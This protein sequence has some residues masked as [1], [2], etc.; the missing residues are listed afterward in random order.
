MPIPVSETSNATTEAAPL[1]NR[2]IFAPAASRH[3]HRQ[4]HAAVLGELECVREQI[5]QHLLQ[6]LGV[7]NQAARKMRIGLNLEG[8]LPVFRFVAERTRDHI[9]QAGE[10][11]FL[12]FH[13]HRSGFDLRK[14]ENVADQVEQVRSRA[15]NGARE[16]HLLRAS[17]CRPGCR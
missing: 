3:G 1:K 6:A 13:R 7:G 16:L 4:S 12:R 5:L 15:V 11:D 17:S 14:I 2:M 8:Q 9:Q 10:E